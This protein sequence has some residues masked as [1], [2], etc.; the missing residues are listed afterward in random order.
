MR[1]RLLSLTF[2][3]CLSLFLSPP[4]LFLFLAL[5]LPL[6]PPATFSLS[7][8]LTHTYTIICNWLLGP[9]HD[10]FY[11]YLCTFLPKMKSQNRLQLIDSFQTPNSY[12]FSLANVISVLCLCGCQWYWLKEEWRQSPAADRQRHPSANPSVNQL[13][14]N[15]CIQ[16]D[17]NPAHM[18]PSN[19]EEYHKFWALPEIK[20]SNWL[21]IIEY[22]HV[23]GAFTYFIL[24]KISNICYPF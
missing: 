7:L 21:M 18:D 3:L 14:F 5:P 19:L 22:N 8:P 13:S 1:P 15:K 20:V 17:I 4:P 23:P 9:M 2:P 10:I 11:I 16:L 24:V 6:T 12:A